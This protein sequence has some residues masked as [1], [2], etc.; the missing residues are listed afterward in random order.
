MQVVDISL[1]KKIH[2]VLLKY[3]NLKGRTGRTD[4]QH[5][6]KNKITTGQVDQ[7]SGH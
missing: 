5:V 6:W 2:F 7:K 1:H 4:E 3:E